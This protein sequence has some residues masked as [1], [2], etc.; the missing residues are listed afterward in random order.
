MELVPLASRHKWP[1]RDIS[2]MRTST[3]VVALGGVLFALPL[4]GTFT[5]G[6]VVAL[7]GAVLRWF[8]R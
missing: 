1:G 4:P 6:A 5:L 2:T 8:G 7:V 3:A